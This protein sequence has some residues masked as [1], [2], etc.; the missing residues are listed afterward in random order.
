MPRLPPRYQ[1]DFCGVTEDASLIGYHWTQKNDWN[2]PTGWHSA[3]HSGTLKYACPNQTCVSAIERFEQA[4]T[5]WFKN[6]IKAKDSFEAEGRELAQRKTDKWI[7]DN[8]RP[9]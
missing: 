5:K 1:C 4:F 9:G 7:S 2:P 6:Y 8:P 3:G